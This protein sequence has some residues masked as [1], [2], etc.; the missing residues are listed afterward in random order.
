MNPRDSKLQAMSGPRISW[1]FVGAAIGTTAVIG[2]GLSGAS[3]SVKGKVTLDGKPLAGAGVSFAL[4]TA[5]TGRSEGLFVGVTDNQ[6]GFALRPAN[7]KSE[8]M[9]AGK[10]LVSI[11]TTYVEGGVPDYEQPPRERVPLKYRKGIEFEVP[12][13]GTSDANFDLKSK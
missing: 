7:P 6:G 8:G 3:S 2:C 1:L 13:G 5:P 12:A 4:T 10:Y 9:P 11:T